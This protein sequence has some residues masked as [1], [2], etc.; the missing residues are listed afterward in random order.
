MDPSTLITTYGNLARYREIRAEGLDAPDWLTLKRGFA[1][2][3]NFKALGK[4]SSPRI[5]NTKTGW[6]VLNKTT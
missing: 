5:G 2:Y 1:L 6:V 4:S 3:G